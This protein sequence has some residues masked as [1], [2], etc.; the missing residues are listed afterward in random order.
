MV[1]ANECKTVDDLVY[2]TIVGL[3]KDLTPQTKPELLINGEESDEGEDIENDDE[4]ENETSKFVDSHRPRDES[5]NSKKVSR[6]I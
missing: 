6:K 4:N 3:G 5:P 2:R 1:K